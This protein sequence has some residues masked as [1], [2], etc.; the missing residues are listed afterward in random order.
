M[1]ACLFERSPDQ[2]DFESSHFFVEVDAASDV[3]DCGVARAVVMS[4]DD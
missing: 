3:A 4:R 1:T 2:I